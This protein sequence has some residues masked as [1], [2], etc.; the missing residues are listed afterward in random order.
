MPV[1]GGM[2][3]APVGSDKLHALNAASGNLLWDYTTGGDVSASPT[4][5][6]GVVYAGSQDHNVYAFG[7][8]RGNEVKQDAASKRP[9]LKTLRP[10]FG[11]KAA[12]P[13]TT[14]RR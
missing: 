2:R 13:A 8:P 10:D 12:K 4:V 11:L 3:Y 7:L 6:N 1:S 14:G 9:A 5:T